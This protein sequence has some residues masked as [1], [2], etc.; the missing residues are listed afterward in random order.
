MYRVLFIED[1]LVDQM[2]AMRVLKKAKLN[3]Q[4]HNVNNIA[5]GLQQLQT[6]N[7]DLVISDYHLADG[8]AVDLAKYLQQ[9]PLILITG[10]RVEDLE[11]QAK[12]IGAVKFIRK[13]QTLNYLASLPTIIRE[14]LPLDTSAKLLPDHPVET[15]DL[16]QEEQKI[17]LGK[18]N[19]LFDNNQD[20]I[21]EIIS[22]FL[23]QD[24]IDMKELQAALE[25]K[26]LSQIKQIAH[27][28]K[29]RYQMFG[30]KPQALTASSIEEQITFEQYSWIDL[31]AKVQL[32]HHSAK[33]IY[34][35]LKKHLPPN[36]H[37]N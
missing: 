28:V 10:L 35:Q 37:Y 30:L 17:N 11:D 27:K 9:I 33:S 8:T 12:S 14:I 3:L 16:T 7:F 18:L 26:D 6:Q 31:N 29:S 36:A 21:G 1:D 13:D 4:V 2:A 22:A 24:P 15:T 23:M 20:A 25:E 34:Q 32:L 5:E 19:Q